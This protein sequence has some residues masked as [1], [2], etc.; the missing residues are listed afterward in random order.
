VNAPHYVILSVDAMP[1]TYEDDL[2][3]QAPKHGTW[4]QTE[5]DEQF[6]FDYLG[7][8]YEGG[9]HRK[10][11][12]ELTEEEFDAW[13]NDEC[14]ANRWEAREDGE[15]TMGMIT[16]LGWLPAYAL[17]DDPMAWNRGGVTQVI[18]RQ[19][20]VGEYALASELPEEANALYEIYGMEAPA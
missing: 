13:L 16:D 4:T 5:G 1:D 17:N 18:D 8:E 2:C 6:E 15:R 11:V 10:W 12:A 20:Y 19:A 7:E 14:Y 3:L 9:K